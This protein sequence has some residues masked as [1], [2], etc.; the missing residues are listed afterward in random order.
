MTFRSTEKRG[1]NAVMASLAAFTLVA[2][3]TDFDDND[4]TGARFIRQLG[5][6]HPCLVGSMGTGCNCGPRGMVDMA[7]QNIAQ[8]Q[9]RREAA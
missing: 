2:R 4:R 6:G 1:W 8:R 5:G 3:N 9:L 7:G